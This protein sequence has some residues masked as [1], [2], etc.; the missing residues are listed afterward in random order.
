[1]AKIKGG[2]FSLE[3]SGKFGNAIVYDKRGR[4]RKH[5]DPANPQT[6]GQMAVRNV[7]GDIQRELKL[8]GTTLREELKAGFGST[9]NALI[10][11]ELMANGNAALE[12][13]QA[14]YAAFDAGN[15]T[16]WA[17]ADGATPVALTD[18]ELLYCVSSAAYDMGVRLGVTLTL[19]QPAAA[20]SATVGAE[21]IAN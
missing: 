9:W 21:W 13:Y 2:L 18:G 14:E 4:A 11:K 12:A 1:M 7:L 20:N 5:V 15:K 3:A 19:T 8:L 10:I 6:D 17:T 16:D